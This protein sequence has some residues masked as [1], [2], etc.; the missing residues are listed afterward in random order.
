M[1][2]S[3][4]HTTQTLGFAA[5]LG[6]RARGVGSELTMVPYRPDRPANTSITP[7][8]PL[9]DYGVF[10]DTASLQDG[11]ETV[12]ETVD[13]T[14]GETLADVPSR[15]VRGLVHREHTERSTRVQR[16]S[17]RPEQAHLDPLRSRLDL[18]APPPET[19]TS[20]IMERIQDRLAPSE[21]PQDPSTTEREIIHHWTPSPADPEAPQLSPNRDPHAVT[22]RAA[23]GATLPLSEGEH[24][25]PRP[26]KASTDVRVDLQPRRISAEQHEQ[27]IGSTS[28]V[29]DASP[30]TDD[31]VRS[32]RSHLRPRERSTVAEDLHLSAL[33]QSSAG[34]VV[35]IGSITV[36]VIEV[37]KRPEPRRVV[38]Q[39]PRR[40]A[41]SPSSGS[42]P[43]RRV[44][45]P[46]RTFG[47]RQL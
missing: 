6:T 42:G 41:Q 37:P 30:P 10:E 46:L 24:A 31:P 3:S 22:T 1:S 13:E 32:P 27:R 8:S 47:L 18:P 39:T 20:Q 26:A 4:P 38:Q 25:D 40:N 2:E 28:P 14:T 43:E 12:D 21:R 23:T 34:P 17:E 19:T 9:A 36:E 35:R 44:S 33:A 5:R 16:A 15:G 29:T 11:G 45:R 7:E